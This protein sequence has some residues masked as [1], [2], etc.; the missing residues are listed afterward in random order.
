MAKRKPD[1]FRNMDYL[2]KN[3]RDLLKNTAW[4]L[5][6]T[7]Y[8]DKPVPVFIVKKRLS[9]GGDA[10]TN[11][12]TPAKPV[13]I[14]QGLMYGLPLRRCL[15]V[16]RLIAGRIC[17]HT[18]VP[19]ELHR[20]FNNGRISYRGNLPLDEESGVKLSLIFR[21]Q[22]RMKDMNRVE[23]IARR[24]ERFSREEAAYWL[25]RATQYGAEGNRWAL[26]G[27]RVMLGGQPADNAVLDMLEKIRG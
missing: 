16:I 8:N 19:L 12:K 1:S 4:L 15:P 10:E 25:S 26:A 22:E 20:L 7:E 5:R 6:I 14:D 9:P 13:L 27:M 3:I 2:Q 24:V 21:L 17:D 23:L 18:G 11:G